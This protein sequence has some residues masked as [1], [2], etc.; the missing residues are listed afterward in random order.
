MSWRMKRL[1]GEG[2]VRDMGEDNAREMKRPRSCIG[3]RILDVF[4]CLMGRP[5]GMYVTGPC[6]ISEKLA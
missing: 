3:C 4:V 1:W 5:G 6:S 2:L